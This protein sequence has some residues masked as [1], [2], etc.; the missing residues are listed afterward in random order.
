MHHLIAFE[1]V[2]LRPRLNDLVTPGTALIET[3]MR[4]S[5]VRVWGYRLWGSSGARRDGCEWSNMDLMTQPERGKKLPRGK[6]KLPLVVLPLVLVPMTEKQRKRAVAA[7]RALFVS[8]V[9]R[10]RVRA[11]MEQRPP[12]DP[13][14]ASPSAAPPA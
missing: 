4:H 3:P 1:T 12:P 5:I 10:E 7:L 11:A 6:S 8:H 2:R 14:G 9:R 13:S